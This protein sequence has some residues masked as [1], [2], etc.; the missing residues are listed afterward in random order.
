MGKANQSRRAMKQRRRAEQARARVRGGDHGDEARGSTV[1]DLLADA[2]DAAAGAPGSGSADA[3]LAALVGGDTGATAR[4]GDVG[5]AVARAAE[6]LLAQLWD[7]GWQPADV[8]RVVARDL[9]A[10]AASFVTAAIADESRAYVGLG[11]RVAPSWTDQLDEIG[12][13]GASV[14]A[15]TSAPWPR[16]WAA[17]RAT[18]W[19]D[20]VRVAVDVLALLVR[21]PPLA[22]LMPPPRAW[23]DL[24]TSG[25]SPAQSRAS[26]D[27][28][29]LARVRALLAKA[30]STDFEDEALAFTAKAQELMTR[31]RIDR[32]LLDDGE[33]TDAPVASARRIGID[34]PYAGPKALLLDAVADANDCR[35]VWSRALGFATVFGDDADLDT[36][37]LLF[38]SL[39]VQSTAAMRAAGAGARGGARARSR[40]FRQSFL[41]G[42]ASRIRQRLAESATSATA[43]AERE[44]GRSLVPVLAA[45]RAAADAAVEAVFPSMSNGAISVS[46]HAGWAM[47]KAAAELADLTAGRRAVDRSA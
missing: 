14:G 15:G 9:G 18:P 46:D 38:T 30:E 34:D 32:L 17:G 11:R 24:P 26:V 8:A 35:S 21:L 37:T 5:D 28:K 22:R 31:H 3:V 6:R 10:A 47:G 12:A 19:H 1:D 36:V 44:A 42:Y 20:A 7:D 25:V 33:S 4:R 39:L 16:G 27:A 29:V 43:A 13:T 2:V 23:R 41:V 40:A 45:R